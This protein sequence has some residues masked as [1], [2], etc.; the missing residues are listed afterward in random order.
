MGTPDATVWPEV[1]T[2][3]DYLPT[4]PRWPVKPLSKAVPGLDEVGLDL[5]S[6]RAQAW[7]RVCSGCLLG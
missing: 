1:T 6:V 3:P 4:F 5:L 7:V 2:L